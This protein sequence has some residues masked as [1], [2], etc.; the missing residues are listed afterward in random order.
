MKQKLLAGISALVVV[1]SPAA[2][3]Q[4]S[5]LWE[6]WAQVIS[7]S[8]NFPS[9][10]QIDAIT[11][12]NHAGAV[13]NVTNTGTYTTS[14]TLNYTNQGNMSVEPSMDFQ[15]FPSGL[16]QPR[17][18]ANFA[19]LY[20]GLGGGTIRC[21]GSFYYGGLSG[22][23]YGALSGNAKITI[24][25]TNI[26]NS[27]TIDMSAASLLKL[28][29]KNVDLSR[30]NL[31]QQNV[32]TFFNAGILDSYW[33]ATDDNMG[34]NPTFYY[35]NIGVSPPHWAV[36]RN[37]QIVARGF[38]APPPIPD[39]YLPSLI[40]MTPYVYDWGEVNS[41]RLVQA[42]FLSN[43]DRSFVNSVY[44]TPFQVAVQW[45]WTSTLWPGNTIQTN[46][47]YLTDN[48]GEV[49][50]IGLV[51]NGF[52]N[53]QSF[54]PSPTYKPENYFFFEGFPYQGAPSATPG[55]LLGVFD[56]GNFTNQYT[57]YEALFTPATALPTDIAGGTYSNMEGRV[58]IRAD[59]TLNLNRAQI[60]SLNYLRLDATNHFRGSQGAVITTP[61]ADFNLRSTN[62]LLAITNLIAPFISHP[63]GPCDLYSARWTNVNNS[64]TNSYH[65][66]IV[67]SHMTPLTLPEVANLQLVVTNSSGDAPRDILIN[68]VL[69]VNQQML[70][71]AR[72][73]TVGRNS[74]DAF[75]P[76]GELNLDNGQI[77][78]STATPGLEYLTNW[79][80]MTMQNVVYF[81]GS[82][83]EPP[84]NGAVDIPYRGFVNHGVITNMGSII[85]SDYMQNDGV[86]DAGLGSIIL[87][88]C[89]YADL[90]GGMFNAPMGQVTIQAGTLLASNAVIVSGAALEL[91]LTNFVTDG[92][93]S[94]ASLTA[95]QW[96]A[97]N[98][99]SLLN[100][101]A[102]GDLLATTVTNIV[103]PYAETL[104]YWA[105]EDRGRSVSG[106]Q[107]NCAIGRLVLVAGTNS[108]F[109]FIGTGVANGLYVDSLELVGN[110]G[111]RD[112]AGNFTAFDIDPNITIYF[113]DAL[114][115]GR[116]I[117][118][119]LD[120]KNG[121]HLVWVSSYAGA[122]S[123]TN[124]LYP[125]GKI[126]SFNRALVQ[127]CN[128]DSDNDGIPNCSDSTPI[129]V[130][131]LVQLSISITNQPA[132]AKVIR[133]PTLGNSTNTLYYQTS[134]T[135]TNWQTL[136]NF[137]FGP[138]NGTAQ[139]LDAS[140]NS[141]RYYRL[142]LDPRVP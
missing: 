80:I 62:G 53:P 68:D 128:L 136:T 127:S 58:E 38:P 85:W 75:R 94:S 63:H 2:L 56:P 139:V 28:T 122:Y 40:G 7:P 44:F 15:T 67:E 35:G 26:V 70:L 132:G 96:S 50:N 73:V 51:L 16:G 102:T 89:S 46:Y 71:S 84:Y 118:E 29:G 17:M 24:N 8:T 39:R 41:N 59:N 86:F 13:F 52:V 19:N 106:Y 23:F 3:A 77:V 10:P 142:R 18:A 113:A 91:S 111:A 4:P 78:W 79:G 27:G 138:N 66:L 83:S 37:Y 98:G 120:G 55:M 81:G 92:G 129:W 12:W 114:L 131:G 121:G 126:Y 101:P 11:F 125:D 22:I 141:T 116:S 42:V 109:H 32:Q 57:A 112:S 95:N 61:F 137:V 45:E 6:N 90:S 82:R 65:V 33:N 135:S 87:Q 108:A 115:N 60:T 48:F 76:A 9:A 140:T 49:T 1:L 72:S 105:G 119:K 21:A 36:T 104:N 30:G 20:S 14:D 93:V 31:H 34:Y 97:Q 103:A 5:L 133:W 43:T 124:L 47:L 64:I 88:S 123:S 74:P 99:F 69:T 130:P 134:N 100:K 110:A 117:A 54:N 25:A 107:D